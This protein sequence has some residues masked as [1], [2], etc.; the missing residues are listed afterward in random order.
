MANV[1]V[2]ENVNAIPG[3][4]ETN[5]DFVTR[6]VPTLLWVTMLCIFSTTYFT[7]ANTFV[8]F[9]TILHWI[10]PGGTPIVDPQVFNMIARKG[11]HFSLYVGF[12]LVLINGP[13][14]GRPW[15]ALLI[16]V[17]AGSLDETHQIFLRGRTPS[18]F[19]VAI[20]SSGAFFG[21]FMN[22]AVNE[23]QSAG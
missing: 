14:E 12:F 10:S 5:N 11:A 7:A 3:I 6:W 17:I 13:L 1:Q 16:C 2:A 9:S 15:V 23:V 21:C 4:V 19:D 18:M 20:D 8:V 22:S